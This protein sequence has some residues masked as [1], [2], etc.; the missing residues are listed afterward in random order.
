MPIY[1]ICLHSLCCYALNC[2]HIWGF[3]KGLSLF[4][5]SIAAVLSAET[6][7][8]AYAERLQTGSKKGRLKRL[9]LLAQNRLNQFYR[10]VVRQ[11][12]GNGTAERVGI[13][14]GRLGIGLQNH[15]TVGM[16]DQTA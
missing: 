15:R 5:I 1:L 14:H 7:K 4:K 12:F 2:I 6:S 13:G 10:T 9:L 8:N 11:L 3:C 16:A